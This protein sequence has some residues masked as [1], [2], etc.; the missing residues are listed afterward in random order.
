MGDTLQSAVVLLIVVAALV[1]VVRRAWRRLKPRA[2]EAS[3]QQAGPGAGCGGCSG[4]SAGGCPSAR[5]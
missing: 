2:S 4:C 5:R 1:D 3:G